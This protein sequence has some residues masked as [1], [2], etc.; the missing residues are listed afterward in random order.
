MSTT[1]RTSWARALAVVS[2][3]A[4]VV[5]G[6]TVSA[7]AAVSH[8]P[9]ISARF[10]D[11]S[12]AP[13]A[14]LEVS[15]VT[16][17]AE[18][19]YQD[20]QRT[21]SDGSVTL[22]QLSKDRFTLRVHGDE[23]YL[24]MYV[25]SLGKTSWTD[26]DEPLGYR[27]RSTNIDTGTHVVSAVPTVTVDV[28]NATG[29]LSLH[30]RHVDGSVWNLPDDPWW[31]GDN[32]W[33]IDD[34]VPTGSTCTF[35]LPQAYLVPGQFKVDATSHAQSTELA[36][37]RVTPGKA[38]AVHLHATTLATMSGTVTVAGA[39]S[40][41]TI[42]L[43]HAD[44]TKLRGTSD[45]S[46]HYA[47]TGLKPG[48]WK[49]MVVTSTPKAGTST[50]FT[51]SSAGQKVVRNFAVATDPRLASLTVRH[52]GELTEATLTK[53]GTYQRTFQ[54]RSTGK[55]TFN[56]LEPGTYRVYLR[57]AKSKKF[58][59]QD[60]AVG[61]GE[62][63]VTKA[64]SMTRPLVKISLTSPR[65]FLRIN[66]QKGADLSVADTTYHRGTYSYSPLWVI[67]ETGVRVTVPQ[68]LGGED[69]DDSGYVGATRVIDFD[70]TT[71]AL[72][73]DGGPSGRLV[74]NLVNA[75]G[76]PIQALVWATKSDGSTS[77]AP[78]G[79]YIGNMRTA[80][81]QLHAVRAVRIPGE[82]MYP[83]RE[84]YVIGPLPLVHPVAGTSKTVTIAVQV[85]GT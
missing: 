58:F 67:P 79:P 47:I 45:A 75:N 16:Q 56:Y 70:R 37:F 60:I 9:T 27:P 51:V 48:T 3:S 23:T 17:G 55:V 22:K 85:L 28:A 6:L 64:K 57:S 62:K 18:Y 30:M 35:A 8:T 66:L 13:V 11:A 24:A 69:G 29:P 77:G 40:V 54:T 12:G 59:A 43:V 7:Q 63:R 68:D 42:D 10:V 71:S 26:L 53:G 74:V 33:K 61:T 15:V 46:G 4:L 65:S 44:G 2:A 83:V 78:T 5:A 84:P 49:A 19:V 82:A 21:A 32:E 1:F 34:C 52:S 81:Y 31:D 39:P 41:R 36:S 38:T 72:V 25:G 20:E 14:G 50:T 76:A 80:P 73:K